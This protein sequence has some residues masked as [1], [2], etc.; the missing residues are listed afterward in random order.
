A[1]LPCSGPPKTALAGK[2]RRLRAADWSNAMH[3]L[4]MFR[5]KARMPAPGEALPGR[6]A[7]IPTADRHFVSGLPLHPPFPKDM[8][9]AMFGLGCFWGAERIFWQSPGVYVTMVG[10]AGGYTPN[11]TYQEVCS[12]LTGHNEVVRLVF[13]PKAISYTE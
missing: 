13:D 5:K 10:Y 6:S 11:P 9:I 2:F 4:D 7:S 1:Y 12:G 3:V 8:E